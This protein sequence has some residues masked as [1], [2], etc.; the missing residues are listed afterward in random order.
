MHSQQPRPPRP[1]LPPPPPPP[2]PPRPYEQPPTRNR[3]RHQRTLYYAKRVQESLT[4]RACKVFCS[5]FLSLLLLTGIILF[6]LYLSLR[7]HRPNFHL[8]SFSVPGLTLGQTSPHPLSVSFEVSDNNPNRKI[9]IYYY[10]MN[11]TVFYRDVLVGTVP[12]LLVGFY[13]PPKNTMAVKGSVS[14]AA[15]VVNEYAWPVTEF[16]LEMTATIRFRLS[17]FDTH[18]H[19]MH[20]ECDVVVGADGEVVTAVKAKRLRRWAFDLA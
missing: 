15:V 16:R 2:P 17:T 20:V 5:I 18:M 12:A 4:S 1:Q 3:L 7:P 8:S 11:G 9:G 14:S 13:Q 6:V 19:D 10:T